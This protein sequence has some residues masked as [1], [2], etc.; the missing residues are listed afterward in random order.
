VPNAGATTMKK[1]GTILFNLNMNTDYHGNQ[2]LGSEIHCE[3]LAKSFKRSGI[4]NLRHE[5][6]S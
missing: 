4:Y 5:K 6:T 2:E 1:A 3:N